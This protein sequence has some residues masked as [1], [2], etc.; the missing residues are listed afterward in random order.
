MEIAPA[1]PA[2]RAGLKPH[3]LVLAVNGGPVR[4]VDELLKALSNHTVFERFMLTIAR[5]G[6]RLDLAIAPEVR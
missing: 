4:S 6:A 5:N 2:S 1:S 3:D